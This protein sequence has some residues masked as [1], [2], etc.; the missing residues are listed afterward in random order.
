VSIF[1]GLALG[2][3]RL[4]CIDPPWPAD[5]TQRLG[6]AGRR[7]RSRAADHYATMSL[8]DIRALPISDLAAPDAWCVLWVTNAVMTRGD[9]AGLLEGWGFRPITAVTWC[10]P[11]GGGLGVYFRG[12]TEHALIGVRGTG[13]VPATP[14]PST[15]FQA[16]R[17]HHSAK[18]DALMDILEL[19]GP[20]P[21][22]ELFQRRPRFGWDG[23]GAGYESQV[24]A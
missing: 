23:W 20:T 21:R 6:G 11:G 15:W 5:I 4:V 22:V 24:S 3:Y 10:K 7:R 2:T 9:H 17:T 12:A 13:T 8:D 16:A 19:V 18:P 14:W 1:D